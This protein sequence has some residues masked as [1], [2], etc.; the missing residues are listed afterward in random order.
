MN[1]AN[2]KSG[3]ISQSQFSNYRFQ[4]FARYKHFDEAAAVPQLGIA[5]LRCIFTFISQPDDR[6][7]HLKPNA[8]SIEISLSLLSDL[9]AF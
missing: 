3:I 5:N 9:C 1:I 7:V 4:P 2:M 6:I 8:D